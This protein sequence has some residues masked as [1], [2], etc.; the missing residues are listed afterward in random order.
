MLYDI[1]VMANK[2]GSYCISMRV[3]NITM[4]EKLVYNVLENTLVSIFKF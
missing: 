3:K 2:I 1:S 4:S